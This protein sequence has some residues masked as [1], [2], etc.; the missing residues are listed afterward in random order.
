MLAI[1]EAIVGL[2]LWW[3]YTFN[4][5]GQVFMTLVCYFDNIISLYT[6]MSS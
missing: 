4:C 3:G 2:V 6:W 1:I 5:L